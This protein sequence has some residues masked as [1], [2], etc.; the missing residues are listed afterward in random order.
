MKLSL[1]ESKELLFGVF[2][3]AKDILKNSQ[4]LK[5]LL[6]NAK[7]RLQ[8]VPHIGEKLSELPVIISM[9][10]SYFKGEYKNL[11]KRTLIIMV[12]AIFYFVMPVDFVTDAVPIIGFVDDAAVLSFCYSLVS[13]DINKYK[14]WQKNQL[15]DTRKN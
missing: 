9:V 1:K 10:Y 4:K 15:I 5:D 14:D 8:E 3:K 11:S 12:G 6:E 13:N 2:G 7:I